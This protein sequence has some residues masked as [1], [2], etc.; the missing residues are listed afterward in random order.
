[1]FI[2]GQCQAALDEVMIEAATLRDD[3][4]PFEALLEVPA[5]PLML[6]VRARAGSDSGSIRV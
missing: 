4:K 2:K 5:K 6:T 1:V 3:F